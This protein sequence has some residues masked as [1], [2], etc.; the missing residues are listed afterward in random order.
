MNCPHCA[1]TA[2]KER[3]KKTSPGYRTFCCESRANAL[4]TS[5]PEPLQLPGISHR[6]YPAGRVVA[7][8]VQIESARSG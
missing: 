8:A 5:V 7:A 4:S 1:S 6:C 2:T 3:T